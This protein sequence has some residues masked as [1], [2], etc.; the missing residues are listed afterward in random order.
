M[1]YRSENNGQGIDPAAPGLAGQ[2]P[3]EGEGKDVVELPASMECILRLLYALSPPPSHH[4]VRVH[5]GA[6]VRDPPVPDRGL[7]LAP[8]VCAD[9]PSPL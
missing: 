6:G 4:L 7:F 1:G 5:E 3:I 8:E 2:G 9:V